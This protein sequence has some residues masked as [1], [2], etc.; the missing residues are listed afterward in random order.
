M[1]MERDSSLQ[2]S[3]EM[4][5]TG[6][7]TNWWSDIVVQLREMDGKGVW[8]RWKAEKSLGN[9]HLS[10]KDAIGISV[11]VLEIELYHEYYMHCVMDIAVVQRGLVPSVCRRRHDQE[12]VTNF[13]D[14]SPHRWMQMR[15]PMQTVW[16]RL[17]VVVCMPAHEERWR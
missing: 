9:S 15:A 11:I 14:A 16:C 6:W 12:Y 8:M 13:G 5:L 10:E 4:R 3:I 7:S 1:G 2:V 17:E